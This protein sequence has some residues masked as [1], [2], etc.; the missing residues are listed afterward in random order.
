[1]V[2]NIYIITYPFYPI[3]HM[4]LPSCDHIAVQIRLHRRTL[5][6]NDP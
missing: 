1:M 6:A 4:E 3:L 5:F 2:F